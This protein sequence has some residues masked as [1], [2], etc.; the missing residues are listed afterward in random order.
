MS[1]VE[2]A[3]YHGAKWLTLFRPL[4]VLAL[5]Y[6]RSKRARFLSSSSKPEYKNLS[7]NDVPV[8]V[9]GNIS[10][11]GTGKTP[12]AVALTQ[13]LV[14]RGKRVG[15][16][17]RG[18]GSTRKH[19]P[20]EVL[21]SSPVQEAGDEPLLLKQR[22]GCPL[23]ISPDRSQAIEYLLERH[24]VDVILSD[25][26]MQHYNMA[27][28]LE[29][30]LIDGNRGLGNGRMLPEGPLREPVERLSSVDFVVVNSPSDS[31][32]DVCDS[33]Q[34]WYR[35]FKDNSYSEMTI[36]AGEFRRLD[37]DEEEVITGET[38]YAVSG[39]GNPNRFYNTLSRLGVKSLKKPF[40]DHHEFSLLDFV[41]M[42]DQ[43]IVMTEKDAVKCRDLDLGN[44]VYLSID[45]QLEP[46]LF[47]QIYDQLF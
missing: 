29:I 2:S 6:A 23:V 3:W 16:V 37:N 1:R 26:G 46:G 11:G 42:A 30:A 24:D 19:F 7:G 36:Q 13:Y 9:I 4:S 47:D 20:Y 39:I 32:P 8:I 41:D 40:K 31:F 38:V 22:L 18:Y 10:V 28:S 21:H 12:F 25:D 15:I 44:S 34:E 14:N 17:S 27:R 5:A 33:S 35:W 43:R 45:A